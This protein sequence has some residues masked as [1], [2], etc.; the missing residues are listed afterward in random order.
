[1][2]AVTEDLV[3]DGI[4]EVTHRVADMKKSPF[5]AA[6]SSLYI[7]LAAGIQRNIDY[8]KLPHTDLY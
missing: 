4:G 2:D 5:H 1:L 6:V 8:P 3:S 7:R